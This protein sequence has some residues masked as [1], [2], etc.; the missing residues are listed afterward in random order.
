MAP[1]EDD[2]KSWMDSRGLSAAE[3]ARSLGTEEQ[4]VRKWRSQ[5]VPARRLP[6]V[7][8]YMAEWI[9]PT[10]PAPPAEAETNILRIEFDD[11]ELDDVTKA[12]AIV[13]TPLREFIRR[14]TIHKAREVMAKE[15]AA[16]A[17]AE[18]E[19]DLKVA[20]DVT[21]YRFTLRPETNPGKAPAPLPKSEE[22]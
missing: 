14:A 7:V 15:K 16:A 4:T 12:A 17:A 11:T 10:T 22:A 2:L 8:R 3:V 6:H 9:D 19:D 18:Q 20:D 5:G 1:H 21:P 13:D